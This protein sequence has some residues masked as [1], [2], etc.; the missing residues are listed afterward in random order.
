MPSY[1]QINE[2]GICVARSELSGDVESADMIPVAADDYAMLGMRWNG[3]SWEA[4]AAA[5]D[6]RP[7][8]VITGVTCSDAAAVIQPGDVTCPVGSV[9]TVEAEL[10]DAANNLVPI[11][12]AFRM[13]LVARD[14]RERILL[15]QFADG[16]ATIATTLSE[17]GCWRIS[18]D[19]INSGLPAAQQM[20]FGGLEIYVVQ[21]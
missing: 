2:S 4:V 11:N 6:L 14:G 20:R 1:A 13:P 19:T 12:A 7:M 10:Q 17:S 9:L 8:V 5:E 15:A 21:P 3:G 16:A 18:E